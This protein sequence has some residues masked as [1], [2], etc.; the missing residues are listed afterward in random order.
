[1]RLVIGGIYRD[2]NDS[3]DYDGCYS[4]CMGSDTFYAIFEGI[5]HIEEVVEI[6]G[7][8]NMRLVEG[9][10]LA[11]IHKPTPMWQIRNSGRKCYPDYIIAKGN[12]KES[13]FESL[14]PLMRIFHK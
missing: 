10:T 1:M 7:A 11:L 4:L 9:Y 3:P 6:G 8:H 5:T 13:F 14:K 12:C 2:N